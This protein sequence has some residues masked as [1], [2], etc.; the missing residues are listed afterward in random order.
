MLSLIIG[1]AASG[2][3]AYAEWLAAQYAGTRFYLA[4]MQAQDGESLKRIEK[5]RA[6]RAALSFETLECYTDLA[7]L[8]LPKRGL[9]LLDCL[10]NLL[11][12]EL[13]TAEGA[14][15]RADAAIMEGILALLPQAERVLVV[16][17]ELGSSGIGYA[18]ETLQYMQLLAQLHRD[19]AQAADAV[20]EVL[21]GI[22]YYYKGGEQPW[23]A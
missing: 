16:S 1:G 18:G 20:C 21:A 6:Q 8:R 3:S 11:A 12:N 13:Y 5:H 7:A 15:T 10:G 9:V 22:P 17:N 23:R 14:R 2:K 4:T 19:L